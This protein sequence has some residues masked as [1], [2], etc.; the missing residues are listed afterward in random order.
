LVYIVTNISL[1][2]CNFNVK[3][4]KEQL[5]GHHSS[6]V[7]VISATHLSVVLK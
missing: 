1:F 2:L 3:K 5:V 4:L 6:W 7:M